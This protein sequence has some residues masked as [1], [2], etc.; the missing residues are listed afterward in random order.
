MTST[1]C[2]AP[3]GA[4]TSASLARPRATGRR[5]CGRRAHGRVHC[6]MCHARRRDP[7][8][9]PRAGDV[10]LAL[11]RACDLGLLAPTGT[12]TSLTSCP[13][14][15]ARHAVVATAATAAEGF[16]SR[17]PSSFTYLAPGGRHPQAQSMPRTTVSDAHGRRS[18]R[19][20]RVL[21]GPGSSPSPGP[22]PR[23]HI[24]AWSRSRGSGIRPHS[25]PRAS[26]ASA[27]SP[28]S[29]TTV[30]DAHGRRS[31]CG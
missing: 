25:T 1:A 22:S 24:Q 28:G 15:S 21:P 3:T 30:F 27:F 4:S 11:K 20:P 23:A 14:A 18:R 5:V 13:R 2:A 17:R 29:L 10:S 19:A 31:C 9:P 16:Q 8:N 12:L 26:S 6:T 7:H